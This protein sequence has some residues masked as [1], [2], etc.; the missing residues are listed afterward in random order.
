MMYIVTYVDGD[1]SKSE[2]SEISAL[3]WSVEILQDKA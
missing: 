2:I 3:C 1:E